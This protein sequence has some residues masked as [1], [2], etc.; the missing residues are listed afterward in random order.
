MSIPCLD[1]SMPAACRR[2]AQSP[3]ASWTA[4][5]DEDATSQDGSGWKHLARRRRLTLVSTRTGGLWPAGVGF[6][7]AS[8][9]DPSGSGDKIVNGRP[10]TN[11]DRAGWGPVRQRMEAP[12]RCDSINV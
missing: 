10:K 8:D 11:Y 9:G 2:H 1:A 12:S 5:G 6:G 3:K 4:N 7:T